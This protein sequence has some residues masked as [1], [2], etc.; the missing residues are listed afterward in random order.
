MTANPLKEIMIA[1]GYEFDTD[2]RSYHTRCINA[3]L[4]DGRVTIKV[5]QPGFVWRNDE[6]T[7]KWNIVV[8]GAGWA[9]RTYSSNVNAFSILRL[10]GEHLQLPEVREKILAEVSLHKKC[11]KCGG[12]G[13]IRAF[14]YYCNGICFD[15]YGL[16]FSKYK[17]LVRLKK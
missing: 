5:N 2:N 17:D 10:I 3:I 11:E 15:C 13:Y 14:A 4:N 7:K 9:S 16:G 12:E 6:R 8:R 1:A